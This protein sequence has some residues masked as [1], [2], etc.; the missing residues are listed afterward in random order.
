MFEILEWNKFN[1]FLKGDFFENLL[2]FQNINEKD[3]SEIEL[4]LNTI[5]LDFKLCKSQDI[6]GNLLVNIKSCSSLSK[7][8]KNIPS[9][10]E[11]TNQKFEL[12]PVMPVPSLIEITPPFTSVDEMLELASNKDLSLSDLAIMY[13]SARTGLNIASILNK[14]KEI[15][16]I[17]KNSI[18]EGLKGT[19]YKDRILGTQSMLIETA[20]KKGLIQKTINST[21][22]AYTSAIMEVKSSM[23]SD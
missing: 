6:N 9:L 21:F 12:I 4:T 1:V 7:E 20:E 5:R 16:I 3:I 17:V 14:M 13:E 15:V 8:I 11:K 10:N 18:E 2:F 19:H 22:I 23:A